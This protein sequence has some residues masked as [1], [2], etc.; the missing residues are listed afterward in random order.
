MEPNA[1]SDAP[2]PFDTEVISTPRPGVLKRTGLLFGKANPHAGFY[3]LLL[4]MAAF[5]GLTIWWWASSESESVLPPVSDTRTPDE[6][7]IPD[8]VFVAE[9]LRADAQK[10]QGARQRGEDYVGVR[11]NT[12]AQPL[13]DYM[14]SL[15]KPADLVEPAAPEKAE[16]PVPAALSLRA[17]TLAAPGPEP[18][19]PIVVPGSAG[20]QTR[21]QGGVEGF[22]LRLMEESKNPKVAAAEGR[23]GVLISPDAQVAAGG[24]AVPVAASAK[25][26]S[27]RTLSLQYPP[28]QSGVSAAREPAGTQASTAQALAAQADEGAPETMLA[29]RAGHFV[30]G[31]SETAVDTDVAI[32]TV[33]AT[34]HS[35]PLAGGRLLGEWTRLG[36]WYDDL[37]LRFSTLEFNGETY[38]VDLVAFNPST[39]LPAFVSEVDRHILVR[40]G[41]LISG[42]LLETVQAAITADNTVSAYDASGN[43]IEVNATSLG[44]DELR[45]TLLSEAGGRLAQKLSA[46]YERPITARVFVGQDMRLLAMKPVYINRSALKQANAAHG[47]VRTYR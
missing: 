24:G 28:A 15:S 21:A 40:W 26:Y 38:D 17:A 11:P 10:A 1:T 9:G 44:A 33:L 39:R 4:L 31:V 25:T 6:G 46:L 12:G 34:I 45:N 43:L 22:A 18:R 23:G 36:N 16:A 7:A 5:S 19:G 14:R 29:Q 35:G 20:R 8:Q 3:K 32:N 2:H 13:S 30:Y 27:S 41:G 37:S 42:A 47:L